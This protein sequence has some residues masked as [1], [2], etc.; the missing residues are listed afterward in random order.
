MQPDNH[1]SCR[2]R[3]S[4]AA[5]FSPSR[6]NQGWDGSPRKTGATSIEIRCASCGAKL[7]V[8]LTAAPSS[9][10]VPGAEMR[11]RV[12]WLSFSCW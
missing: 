12:A 8:A 10:I 5:I 1:A 7:S 4:L 9:V 2:A 6:P 3:T 11:I